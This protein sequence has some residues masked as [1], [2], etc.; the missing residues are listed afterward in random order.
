MA[1]IRGKDTKPELVVR[2]ALHA[3]G[4]RYRLHG[5]KL[6]GRPDV[7][8]SSRRAVVFVHGCFWH[9]HGCANSVWPKV[10]ELFW[11][12][13]INGN[14]ERDRRNQRELRAQGWNVFVVWECEVRKSVDPIRH[15][16]AS[17]QRL[18]R[19]T[20]QDRPKLALRVAEPPA[21]SYRR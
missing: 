4:F 12:T 11:R 2:R 20:E 1:A 5:K 10:R 3:A 8:L 21:S 7:V 14:M 17:I 16:I 15:L 6:P 13:K 18:P 19:L 9:H